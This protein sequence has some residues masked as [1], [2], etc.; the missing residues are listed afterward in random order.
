METL[1]LLK[2]GEKED[3]VK[4]RLKAIKKVAGIWKNSEDGVQY[5]KRL[6]EQW[7]NRQDSE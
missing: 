2:D 6:R 3:L 7:K 5:Q 1:R 4:R